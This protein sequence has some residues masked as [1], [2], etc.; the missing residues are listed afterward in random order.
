MQYY[1]LSDLHARSTGLLSWNLIMIFKSII[2]VA[3]FH[4]ELLVISDFKVLLLQCTMRHI[5]IQ[6][7]YY[8]AL[9]WKMFDLLSAIWLGKVKECRRT[10]RWRKED[11]YSWDCLIST[12]CPNDA[13]VKKHPLV[14]KDRNLL[15]SLIHMLIFWEMYYFIPDM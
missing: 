1:C 11:N 9:S 4:A 14:A 3:I 13:G 5:G 2:L 15:P 8:L 7:F 6:L 12:V 10:S